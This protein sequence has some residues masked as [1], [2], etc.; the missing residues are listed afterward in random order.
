MIVYFADRELNVLGSASTELPEGITILEDEKTEDIASGEKTFDVTFAYNDKTRNLVVENVAVGNFLLRSADGEN[1]FYTIISTVHSTENQTVQAYCEDA[2]LDLLN[3]EAAEKEFDSAHDCAYYVN[4]YLKAGW[5]I[6][7]N[8]LTSGTRT[9]KFDSDSTVIE[10][11]LSIVNSFN[12]ELDFSYEIEQL[13]VTKRYI[14][15]YQRRGDRNITYQLRLGGDIS[16][17]TTNKSVEELATAFVVTGGTLKGQDKPINLVGAD[18]SSDGTTTHTPADPD[19]DYQIVGNQVRCKS[20]MQKWGSKL[21]SDGLLVRRYSYDT[22]NKQTL[23][24]HAVSEL[25]KVINE[26][27]TYDIEF[28]TFPK[29]ARIGDWA[30]VVDDQDNLYLEGR[31]LTLQK[32]ATLGQITATL[33]E[34]IIRESGISDRLIALADEIRQQALS[35]TSITIN[36]SNGIIF[37]NT[38]INTTLTAIVYYGEEVINNQTRLEEIFGDDVRVKWY[39]NGSLINTGFT[40]NVSSANTSESYIVKVED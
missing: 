24:S 39:Q 12:G 36:S 23:F 5:E 26:T 33:G 9:L 17:I 27:I 7:I 3:S 30:Y 15:L 40:Y 6:G 29:D 25:K 13:A 34:W 21:D 18:Y 31:I 37:N 16:S 4:Y 20:A 1:E 8:E 35:A 11:L 22:T 38:A 2:G 32:S 10:R 28:I 14:N 19:D